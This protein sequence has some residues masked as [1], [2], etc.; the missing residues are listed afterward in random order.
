MKWNQKPSKAPAGTINKE[1]SLPFFFSYIF[2]AQ[3]QISVC[4]ELYNQDGKL[5]SIHT[6]RDGLQY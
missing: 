1:T 2:A 4:F 5:K 6:G 3:I